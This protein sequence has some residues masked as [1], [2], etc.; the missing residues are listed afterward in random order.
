[1]LARQVAA[2]A[3]PTPIPKSLVLLT[4]RLIGG[5]TS[6]G[7]AVVP[8]QT[9]P[10]RAAVFESLGVK[11]IAHKLFRARH[12]A[13]R[14]IAAWVDESWRFHQLCSVSGTSTSFRLAL[15]TYFRCV[16]AATLS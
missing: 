4:L 5:V 10:M 7:V 8:A 13:A 2:R 1:M 12:G 16:K 15:R 3:C 6:P 11:E 14:L 9:T